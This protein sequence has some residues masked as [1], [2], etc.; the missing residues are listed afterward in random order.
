MAVVVVADAVVMMV[1]AIYRVAIIIRR[2]DI[3]EY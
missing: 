3:F 1:M 2:I